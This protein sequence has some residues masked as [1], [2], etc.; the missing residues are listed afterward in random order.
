MVDVLIT[1]DNDASAWHLTPPLLW[2]FAI[3][4]LHM[5]THGGTCHLDSIPTPSQHKCIGISGHPKI[6][7]VADI[8]RKL[9]PRRKHA[10]AVNTTVPNK[11]WAYYAQ[12]STVQVV[13]S[14]LPITLTCR[15][16]QLLAAAHLTM[17][18]SSSRTRKPVENKLR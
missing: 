1:S 18:T 13:L 17:G 8:A 14:V 3:R 15:H 9:D 5:D 10:S 11:H 2:A 4:L 16:L 6:L 12:R 7:L